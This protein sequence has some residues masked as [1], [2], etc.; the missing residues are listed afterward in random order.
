MLAQLHH[1]W[2]FTVYHHDGEWKRA[3]VLYVNLTRDDVLSFLIQMI[4][5]LCV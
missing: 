4:L 5:G 1:F 2:L 3:G